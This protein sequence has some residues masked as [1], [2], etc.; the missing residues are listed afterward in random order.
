MIDKEKSA[1]TLAEVLITLVIIGVVAALTIPT[2]ISKYR[3][4]TVETRV[5]ASFSTLSN[6]VKRATAD[7]GDIA[8]WEIDNTE[9]FL[10]KYMLPYIRNSKGRCSDI[11]GGDKECQL[12]LSNGTIWEVA[13]MRNFVYYVNDGLDHYYIMVKA[14]INGKAKPNKAGYDQFFFYIF[15]YASEI[16]N[17]GDYRIASSVNSPGVYYD[18][19]NVSKDELLTNIRRGCTDTCSGG[20][21]HCRKY[22]TAILA[23]NGW[24]VPDDYPLNL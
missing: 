15:P 10:N 11:V 24:K 21:T 6:A 3:K 13:A 23:R 20:D 16:Y 22:C 1:F 17:T 7:H 14:D 18:G 9:D 5:K 8:L 4:T 2:A 12:I 19:Y